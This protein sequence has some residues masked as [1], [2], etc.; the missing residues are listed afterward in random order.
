MTG[1]SDRLGQ[2]MASDTDDVPKT[3]RRNLF[4]G[5]LAFGAAAGGWQVWVNRPRKFEFRPIEGLPGWRMLEFDGISSPV[6]GVAGAAFLGLG[7]NR[8]QIEPM[9]AARLCAT[10]FDPKDGKVPVASF[11]DFFCPYCRVQTPRLARRSDRSDTKIAVKWH[12]LPLLGPTSEIAAR[13]ALAAGLQGGYPEFQSRLLESPFRPT[14]QYLAE[15]AGSADLRAGQMLLDMDGQVVASR[16][17]RTRAA[18]LT[19]G[20]YGTPALIVGRTLVMGR[21]SE[22]DLDRLIALEAEAGPVEC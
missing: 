22:S 1:A 4:V 6:A 3:S 21:I 16:L 18:A 2:V 19:L 7:D 15:I 13:A 5:L 14:P 17:R 10:L 20:I 12:E 8:E 11:S 9:P